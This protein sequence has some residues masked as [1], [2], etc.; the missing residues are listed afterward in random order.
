ME[1]ADGSPGDK[2]GQG[3]PGAKHVA[4]RLPA[5]KLV[6]PFGEDLAQPYFNHRLTASHISGIL[7]EGF[8]GELSERKQQRAQLEQHRALKR[9]LNH[10]GAGDPRARVRDAKVIKPEDLNDPELRRHYRAWRQ[11]LALDV[12]VPN[13]RAK[14]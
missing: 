4:G 10:K 2:P 12:Q 1:S 6:S 8:R 5:L 14:A 11:G 13:W 9:K 7:L 3:S